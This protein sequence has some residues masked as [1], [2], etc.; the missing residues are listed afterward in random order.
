MRD[1]IIKSRRYDPKIAGDELSLKISSY[2]TTARYL[3]DRLK[4][5]DSTVCE[6]CCGIGISL[7]EFSSSFAKVIGVDADRSV[8]DHCRTNLTQAEV[9]NFELLTGDVN[10]KSLL[11]IINAD[12]VLYDIPY[13]SS[14]D[15]KVNP[16]EQNPNLK[17]LINNI[18]K[19]ITKDIVI[20]TPSHMTYED[21][22]EEVG[23]CEFLEVWLNGK[24]DRNF[25]FL[26]S[27]VHT[28]GKT[29]VDISG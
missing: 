22:S 16:S 12:I 24:H 14:H 8:I 10:S 18:Q 13:W 21:V 2:S 23:V 11:K 19:S 4:D 26:G 6:L 1:D 15:G 27:L 17:E 28:I 29:R 20:Y 3:A 9:L 25:I 7:I 5:K